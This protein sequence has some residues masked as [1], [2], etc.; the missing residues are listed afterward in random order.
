MRLGA[1]VCRSALGYVDKVSVMVEVTD[2]ALPVETLMPLSLVVNE[3][4]TNAVKYAF[5]DR[6][7]GHVRILIRP[8]G[9]GHELLFS[10]DG[11]GLDKEQH[12]LR[13]RSFGLELVEVLA[14][15][16]NGEVRVLNGAGATFCMTFCPDQ[17][18]LRKAS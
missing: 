2:I 10:D 8:S 9:A 16:L 11:S 12:F 6:D 7:R 15:Q 17:P 14:Q 13:E 1:W 3:L 18:A 5:T 4:L